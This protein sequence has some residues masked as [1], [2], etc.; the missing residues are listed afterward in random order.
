MKLKSDCKTLEAPLFP[1]KG[2]LPKPTWRGALE[3][4]LSPAIRVHRF[5]NLRS[6]L[7]YEA[8]CRYDCG[9]PS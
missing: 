8:V 2:N 4:L 9:K 1:A 6:A 5:R 7:F 3:G